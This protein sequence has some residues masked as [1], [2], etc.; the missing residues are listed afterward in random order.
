MNINI[1]IVPGDTAPRYP[2]GTEL[3]CE[4]VTITEQGTMEHLPIVDFKLRGP[5]GKFYLVVMTG[6]I[7]NAIAASIRG[8][9]ERN[10][11]TP[12]P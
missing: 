8:I 12:T 9:N 2:D 7:V 10:H 6:R 1:S 11:G 5:D 3:V 4:G